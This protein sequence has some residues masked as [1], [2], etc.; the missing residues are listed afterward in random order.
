[1]NTLFTFDADAHIYQLADGRIVPGHTQVLV[2]GGLVNYSHVEPDILERKSE[3]GREVHNATFLYDAGKTIKTDARV[4]PHLEAWIDFRRRT[5][6]KPVL[7]EYRDVYELEGR[8]FGMQFDAIGDLDGIE[9][10]VEL[11]I[12][13]T[14]MP[15]HGVQLAAQAACVR[16]SRY[17]LKSPL[18]LFRSRGR[19]VA[20]LK[21]NGSFK[22]HRFID[23]SDFP[24]FVAC[25]HTTYWK[26]QHEKF[27]KGEKQ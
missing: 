3:L 4:E 22:V 15:H 23:P 1:M 14:I 10:L 26:K 5:G 19:V 16:Q 17:H 24:E 2:A 13:S 21:P 11:K 25:L 12:C 18:A 6:F 20:Q 7:R 9:T 27:Y 8:A